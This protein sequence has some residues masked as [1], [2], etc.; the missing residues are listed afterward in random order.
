MKNQLKELLILHFLNDGVR[1]TIIVLLP[2]IAKDLSLSLTQ[3][4][5]LGS[6]QPLVGAFLALPT[7]FILGKFGGYKVILSLLFIYS[8]G[9][10]GAAFALNAPMLIIMYLFA[11]LGFAMFHPAG[12]TL[13][14]KVSGDA[15]VGR[16]MGNFTAIGEIG[17]VAL[18]PIALF[19]SAIIGWRI[20]IGIVG[21]AGILLFFLARLYTPSNTIYTLNSDNQNH[22]NHKQFLKHAFSLFKNKKAARIALAAI[23]DSLASSPIYVYL[24]FLLVA[25][26]SNPIQLSIA[27]GGFFVG[28]L[29]G[30]SLLGRYADK[31]GHSKIFIFSEFFMAVS[32]ILITLSNQF[33]L[34]IFFSALLGAFTKGTSPVVQTLFSQLADKNHYHKV[35]AVSELV[36]TIAS[37]ISI[38]LLGALADKNGI[39]IVFYA[40]ALLALLAILPV[41]TLVR[42]KPEVRKI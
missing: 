17:R 35:F 34:L 22:E 29:I 4:G 2:L 39:S 37:V 36:I 23:I 6:S 40:G 7:G 21:A 12:F 38:T 16:N 25:K 31:F 13:T 41:F 8:L 11:A 3:V 24:P 19:A 14:A 15:N 42:S 10:M 28:S 20:T 30:K 32:L 18:P 33:F 9:V 27:M 1:T 5:F 26:G